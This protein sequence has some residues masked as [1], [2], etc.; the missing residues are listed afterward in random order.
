MSSVVGGIY[1]HLVTE[2]A[3][4][5]GLSTYNFGNG[6]APAIFTTDEIQEDAATPFIR[7]STVGGFRDGTD[8]TYRGGVVIVNVTLWGD[9]NDTGKT[10]R[11]LADTI[12]FALDR[13][14]IEVSGYDVP[15]CFAD[16]PNRL[17]DRDGFPGYSV[18]CQVLVRKE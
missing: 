13:A 2:T 17:T 15:Y 4:T 16:P 6:D 18:S 3:V 8:R 7:I 5:N 1:A 12:W 14:P 9:K 11:E 10:L